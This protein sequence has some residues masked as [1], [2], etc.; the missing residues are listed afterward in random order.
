[1]ILG[2][3]AEGKYISGMGILVA[4]GKEFNQVPAFV[5]GFIIKSERFIVAIVEEKD[6]ICDSFK[7][8]SCQSMMF[9][10][11]L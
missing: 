2:T 10:W 1:M 9:K 4:F 8:K 6:K 7:S 11:C 5:W 3:T